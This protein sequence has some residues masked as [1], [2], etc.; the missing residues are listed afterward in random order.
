MATTCDF[1]RA[2]LVVVGCCEL[3]RT[4]IE[5]PFKKIHGAVWREGMANHI[6]LSVIHQSHL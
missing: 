4:I 2:R 1:N 3:S 6:W 5:V